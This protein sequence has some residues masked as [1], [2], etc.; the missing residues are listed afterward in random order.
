MF[1][2]LVATDPDNQ[3]LTYTYAW[4]K[5]D[6]SNGNSI[7][8][9]GTSSATLSASQFDKHDSIYV[10]LPFQMDSLA[11]LPPQVPYLSQTPSAQHLR[12]THT[13]Q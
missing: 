2:V 8:A 3:S 4:F 10:K 13:I 11:T 6:A 1:T 5:E 12:F 9:I 7:I